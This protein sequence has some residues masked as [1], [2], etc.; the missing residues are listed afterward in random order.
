MSLGLDELQSRPNRAVGSD[1]DIAGDGR[2]LTH[3]RSISQPWLTGAIGTADWTGTSLGVLLREIGMTENAKEVVFCPRRRVRGGER[4]QYQRSF[5]L[6]AALDDEDVI[7]AWGMNGAAL[8]PQHGFPLRLVIPGWYG[9]ANV[10][11]LSSIQLVSAPFRGYEQATAYRFSS[12]RDEPGE[13][14]S[15][16]RVRSLMIPP[17]CPTFSLV[18]VSWSGDRWNSPDAPVGWPGNNTPRHEYRRRNYLGEGAR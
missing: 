2:A 10:K 8:E 9:M 14:V 16:M 7:L 11:W 1:G 6:K 18:L 5:P 17:V 12:S 4:Q 15:F 3:P 13:P